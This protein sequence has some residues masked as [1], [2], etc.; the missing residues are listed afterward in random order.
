MYH[1]LYSS[2]NRP[3]FYFSEQVNA[4]FDG[5]GAYAL[6]VAVHSDEL[7]AA[8][9]AFRRSVRRAERL[10][11]ADSA[12]SRVIAPQA[13]VSISPSG[14]TA[15]IRAGAA[16]AS[17]DRPPGADDRRPGAPERDRAPGFADHRSF[18]TRSSGHQRRTRH[19]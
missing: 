11:A 10:L 4:A 8:E 2:E 7:T 6:Q 13:G 17:V 3:G 18:T 16:D 15:V 5:G 19:R 14:H 1:H 9:P 12:V